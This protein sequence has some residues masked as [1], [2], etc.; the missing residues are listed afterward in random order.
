[1][2]DKW[3]GKQRTVKKWILGIKT[4]IWLLR[5][6]EVWKILFVCFVKMQI[7]LPGT[8]NLVH[9]AHGF[10]VTRTKTASTHLSF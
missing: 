4:K 5:V 3:L 7:S 8:Q 10:S 1:M 9:L 6:Y 2:V